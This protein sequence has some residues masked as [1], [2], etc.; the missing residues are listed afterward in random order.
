MERWAINIDIEG[1]SVLW[2]KEDQVVSALGELMRAI[3]RVGR[4]CFPDSPERLFAHQLGDGFLVASDFGEESLERC[5]SIAVALM[6]HVAASGRLTKAAIAEGELSD[7]QGCYPGEV[8]DELEG[9]H[10][11]SLRMGLMTIFPVMGTALIRSVKVAE[12]SPSGPLLTIESSKADRIA[13]SIPIQPVEGT[14]L[15]AIDWVHMDTPLLANIQRQARLIA[16]GAAK[17]EGMLAR[18]CSEHQLKPEWVASV[19]KYLG[20]GRDE[21]RA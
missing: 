13:A 3:F 19:R 7:I 18:Y 1:F 4:E 21:V 8:L 2:E 20:V 15:S 11:V 17:L 6:Q 9:D 12:A 10:R 16:P 5:V 14:G